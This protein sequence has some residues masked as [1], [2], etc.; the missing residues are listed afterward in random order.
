M[1]RRSSMLAP[2]PYLLRAGSTG[3]VQTR[4]PAPAV[5]PMMEGR[6]WCVAASL[7]AARKDPR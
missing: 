6:W 5:V 3:K 4:R 7:D 2:E 1:R